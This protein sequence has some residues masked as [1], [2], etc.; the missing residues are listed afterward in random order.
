GS[1]T[2]DGVELLADRVRLPEQLIEL[3]F[4][5]RDALVV[6]RGHG[7]GCEKDDEK[8]QWTTSGHRIPPFETRA[9]ER[10]GA[11]AGRGGARPA[12]VT[13][14]ANATGVCVRTATSPRR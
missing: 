12:V 14:T 2:F 8:K 1:P 11:Q 6:L 5:F 7:K 4:E 10:A 3:L 9:A 13:R